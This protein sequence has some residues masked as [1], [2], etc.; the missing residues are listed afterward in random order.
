MMATGSL[1][2][3]GLALVAAIWTVSLALGASALL[4]SR[5]ARRD[6]ALERAAASI[7]LVAPPILGAAAVVAILV[8]SF[9]AAGSDGDH[10]GGHAHHLHLCVVHGAAWAANAWAVAALAAASALMLARVVFLV[11]SFVRGS[12]AIGDLRRVAVETDGVFLVPSDRLFVFTAGIWRGATFASSA[13]W[14]ALGPDE[15]AAA[16]AHE[17]AHQ[18]SRDLLRRSGLALLAIAAAPLIGRRMLSVWDSATE[19]LRDRDAATAVGDETSVASA[20]VALARASSACP[21]W[22]APL[23]P[24]DELSLRVESVLDERG[25]RV[26]AGARVVMAAGIILAAAIPVA[27]VVADPLHHL[28]ETVLGVF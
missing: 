24:A 2:G 16:L 18:E 14:R 11:A 27:F 4:L 17:R 26:R 9:A 15:R 20:L 21:A 23:A 22:S 3:F 8:H 19:R 25:P 28:L 13:A 7:A 5:M 12:R 6:P 10:C 1:V